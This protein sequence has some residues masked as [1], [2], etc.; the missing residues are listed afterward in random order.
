M[1]TFDFNTGMH[2][3]YDAKSDKWE[4]TGLRARLTDGSQDA[5]A[6]VRR[7][8]S[9]GATKRGRERT[10]LGEAEHQ[11]HLRH[12]AGARSAS[13]SSACRSPRDQA[14]SRTMVASR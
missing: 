4:E 7:R 2:V 5:A 12:G 9:H 14:R 11:T 6:E 13:C 1:D 3:V 10:R 8:Q